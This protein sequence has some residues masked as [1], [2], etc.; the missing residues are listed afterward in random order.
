ML[1]FLP[2]MSLEDAVTL[3]EKRLH[4]AEQKKTICECFVGLFNRKLSEV[5]IKE[6][7]ISLGDSPKKLSDEQIE[8][9][10]TIAKGLRV[11]ITGSKSFEQAQVCAGG[12][13]TEEICAETMESKIVPGVY[14]AGELVD[15][16]G[17]CG[18][19]NLQWAWSSGYVAGLH[20]AKR[21]KYDSN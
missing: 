11:D 5:L 1:D 12:V 3:F 17:M 9:L 2:N 19:Y 10:A 8:R 7:G 15:I 6:A 13:D 18:G 4:K 16:D 14:F 21:S 20:A